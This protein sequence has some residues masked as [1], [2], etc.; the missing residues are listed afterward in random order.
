MQAEKT[1]VNTCN[2]IFSKKLSGHDSALHKD[3]VDAEGRDGADDR[4]PQDE[5]RVQADRGQIDKDAQGKG[6]PE[7]DW[8]SHGCAPLDFG[9]SVAFNSRKWNPVS[10]NKARRIV[11]YGA[12][13]PCMCAS[14]SVARFS[15]TRK[16]CCS[17]SL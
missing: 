3:V 17:S 9:V 6:V 13:R 4:K 1:L 2:D 12:C 16:L 8:V 5:F 10:S 7:I 14:M 15:S 11:S